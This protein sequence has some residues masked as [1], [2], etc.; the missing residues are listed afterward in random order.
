MKMK[1]LFALA[2]VGLT[3]LS[4]ARAAT[5]TENFSSDPLQNGW[6]VFG[7]TNLFRWDPVNQVLDVTWDSSQ[8]NSFFYHPIGTILGTNDD[9]SMSFD[10]VL[11]DYA[12]GVN[13]AAPLDFE[14]AAG[15]LNYAE[16]SSTNFLRGSYEATQPDLAE[17][18]FFQWD[19]VAPYPATNTVW[20]TFVDSQNDY[21]WNGDSSFG[22]AEL[23]TNIVMRVTMNYTAA[24]QMCVLTI[25][26]NGVVVVA[27]VVVVLT[28]PGVAFGDYHLDAFAVES[29][30]DAESGGS[31]LA[32]GTIG[33]VVPGGAAA[34]GHLLAARV[35]QWSRAGGVFQPDKLELHPAKQ[36]RSPR[37]VP[38]GARCPRHRRQPDF[39]GHQFPPAASV[40]PRQRR[41]SG[42][43]TMAK[44]ELK[45]CPSCGSRFSCRA[46]SS[47]WCAE[48][49]PLAGVRAD[50]DCFC[51]ECLGRAV[52]EERA[53]PRGEQNRP[54]AKAA[55]GFTLIELLVSVVV[56]GILASILLPV[57]S[58]G[59]ARARTARCGS[60]LRQ[61]VVAAQMYWDDNNG[62]PFPYA[63][64][65]SSNGTCYWFGWLGQGAE[66]TRAFDPTAGPLYPWLAQRGGFLPGV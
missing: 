66:E 59:K 28:A 23:P 13:P 33:N 21:Y 11:N 24:D 1:A 49:P 31:L 16:A 19:D 6:R 29:Y 53:L 18:D 32:H 25:T 44:S 4:A 37:M 40:L 54:A 17:F 43:K 34:S 42:L 20:P 48:F 61:F 14:L 51:P 55:P 10:L 27:P 5:I 52:A 60:N 26:T 30:S 45:S 56:I 22:V 12:I 9:F 7:D 57:L 2:S 35:D 46:G 63:G 3:L 62:Q 15:L 39:A 38:G 50:L 64:A 8:S 47:C 58:G 36:R 41:A 65:T